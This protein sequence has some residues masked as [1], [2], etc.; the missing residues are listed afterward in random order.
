MKVLKPSVQ[1]PELGWLGIEHIESV[2]WYRCREEFSANF[3]ENKRAIYFC[4]HP[5]DGFKVSSFIL[6]TEQI[7][8]IS[9]PN[10]IFSE[11]DR[12]DITFV[13]PSLFWTVDMMRRQLFSIFLRA[14][15]NYNGN[16]YEEALWSP[17]IMKCTYALDTKSAICRFLFGFTNFISDSLPVGFYSSV[18]NGWRETFR[19]KNKE[20]IKRLLVS[21][22][23]RQFSV[24]DPDGLWC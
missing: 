7:V 18:Q 12:D 10:S 3:L 14:S 8:D 19:C 6:K 17:D 21:V 2:T 16:N 24:I 22:E 13:E 4:H 5:L 23:K 11:T 9:E 15:T 1:V 20:E